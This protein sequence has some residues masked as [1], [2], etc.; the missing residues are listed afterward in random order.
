MTSWFSGVAREYATFRPRYPS[1]L[2]EALAALAPHRRL[3]WDCGAGNGQAS[4]AL[5]AHFDQVVATDISAQQMA[6]APS[7]PRLTYR[8]APAQQSGL[9]DDSVALVTV[10][11]ALHWFDVDAFHREAERVLS[12]DGIIAEWCY[13]LLETP[14]VPAVA[15]AV[16]DLDAV[17]RLWWPPERAHVDAHY[18][19]LP[20]PFAPVSLP[21]AVTEAMA[22]TEQWTPAQLIGYASTW[23]A[24]TR[25]R[26]ARSDDPL[27]EFAAHIHAAWGP[28][29]RLTIRWPL[30]VR[31]GRA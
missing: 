20:F 1:A 28:A 29:E 9:A 19:T 18:E 30:V 23:S 26:A 16:R 21:R 8:V 14:E 5:A 24:L 27:V 15:A 25:Y 10:A 12:S 7:H 2:F 4:L 31:V 6:E 11:Q 13:T 3:A 22:M 17:L